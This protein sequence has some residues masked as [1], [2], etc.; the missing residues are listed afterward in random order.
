VTDVELLRTDEGLAGT[1]GKEAVE[2]L[3]KRPRSCGG[4]RGKSFGAKIGGYW[5]IESNHNNLNPVGLFLGEYDGEPVHL[6]SEVHL[7]SHYAVR[8]ADVSGAVG[9]R[10]LNARV[11]PVQAPS[12][13]PAVVGVDGHFHGAAITLF[14]TVAGDLSDAH[15]H[16]VIGGHTVSIDATRSSVTGRYEGPAALFPLLVSCLVYFI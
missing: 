7:T 14:V 10:E 9:D 8:H 11:A 4:V 15:I 16:G 6:R 12:F 5:R 1:V 2:L 13:G 3:L